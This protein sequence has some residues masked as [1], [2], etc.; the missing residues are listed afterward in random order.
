MCPKV[1]SNLR[2]M[3][4]YFQSIF[5]AA[6]FNSAL[7]CYARTPIPTRTRIPRQIFE[8]V[9]NRILYGREAQYTRHDSLNRETPLMVGRSRIIL[10][11]ED[12]SFFPSEPAALDRWL[13]K[14][15]IFDTQY[16]DRCIEFQLNFSF[17]N[18]EKVSK[19]YTY[20]GYT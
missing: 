9:V 13:G 5:R 2:A 18:F 3:S 1:A 12:L 10:Q 8:S 19:M 7:F 15:V 17:V 4:E 16:K 20:V 14:S 11:A 6:T